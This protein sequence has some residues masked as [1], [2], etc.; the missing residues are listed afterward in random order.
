M[1]DDTTRPDDGL[2]DKKQVTR[3]AFLTSVAA[4]GGGVLLSACG[5]KPIK[6]HSTPPA[7]GAAEVQPTVPPPIVVNKNAKK[8]VSFWYEW[9]TTPQVNAVRAAVNA[10][11]KEN[12]DIS[13]KLTTAAQVDTKLVPAITAGNPPDLSGFYFISSLAA[14]RGLM[15]VDDYL[16]KSK[17][18]REQDY[19]DV[20][21]ESE[22]WQGKK[23][24]VPSQENGPRIGLCWNKGLFE[25]AG[26]DPDKGPTTLDELYDY[27][28]K[29]T[30]Q[31]KHGNL[32]Q[33]GFDPRDAMGSSEGFFMWWSGTKEMPYFSDGGKKLHLNNP[34]LIKGV[35][36]TAKIYKKLG[37]EK[38]AGFRNSYGTWTAPSS[39]FAQGKQAIQVNGYWAPGELKAGGKPGLK[40]GYGWLPVPTN[41]RFMLTGGHSLTIP[42]GSQNPD[43]AFKLIEFFATTKAGQLMFDNTGFLN[44]NLQFL[45]NGNFNS[46]PDVKWFINAGHD[47][48][49]QT[50]TPPPLPVWQEVT[51]RFESGMDEVVRGKRSAKDMLD[52]LQSEMQKTLDQV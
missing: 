41:K 9:G 46:T 38:I 47:A 49:A 40:F 21:W 8:T 24:G 27:T 11:V 17:V 22:T 33:I 30:K 43:T 35:E 2:L 52:E 13:V 45:K 5:G 37:P 16:A 4:L 51:T 48:E 44:G 23:Y 36:W 19:T 39:S 26:L 20:Q 25:A 1:A 28:F 32:R 14:R 34:D 6:A 12:P 18:I 15:P 29:L 10:F 7:Q 31:D 42:R 50:S 3:R